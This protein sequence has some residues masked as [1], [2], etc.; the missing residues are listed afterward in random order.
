MSNLQNILESSNC[1][2][3]QEA[4]KI[5]ERIGNKIPAKGYV[6]FETGYGPS[7]LPH[8]GTFGEV[9]RTSIIRHAFTKIS[10]I[11]TRLFAFSDDMDGL[12]KVPDNIPNKDMVRTYLGKPLTSIPDPFGTHESFGHH[13]NNRLRQFLDQFGFEYEF[14]SATDYYKAGK[15]DA[16]LLKTLQHF[17]AIMNVMLPTLGEERQQTYSPI[18]PIC[19]E[20]GEVLQVPILEKNVAKG[21]I[22]FKN[23]K[24]V[25]IEQQ[26]TGGQCKLQWKADWA[27]R[28]C[29][30]DV[31]YE[32]YGKD[33]IPT[34]ELSTKIARILGYQEPVL[35]NYELFLDEKG[36]KISKSKGNGLSMDEWL[37]Y[38][39]EESLSLYMY[40]SPKKAK[41]LFF[42]V[43]P[44]NMDEYLIYL[45]K[46]YTQDLV[47]QV[48]NPVW[49]IHQGNPPKLEP[50]NISF[51]LLLNLASV[52]NPENS[53]VLW[54][55]ISKYAPDVNLQNSP[56]LTKM[57]DFA[58]K[59]YNDFIKP[60]KKYPLLQEI[61]KQTINNLITKLSKLTATA[62][63]D[64]I[65]NCLYDLAREENIESK[66]LFKTLYNMLLG[67][68]Q[69]PRWGTF[70]ALFGINNTIDLAKKA[71][72]RS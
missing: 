70:I 40:Q 28:W 50:H 61:D 3:A 13:M 10:G 16:L 48:E 5:L 49:H 67:Q 22:T 18:L 23:S 71:L 43:I 46:Y 32:M 14:Q 30:L 60:N 11:P 63:N 59:Y 39:P 54:G 51:S 15:F 47:Q 69:G 7:G 64:E 65:Q 29:A 37:T 8:I 26:V 17:D 4:K 44:K 68:D 34:A 66:D 25:I 52:C 12:R 20:S 2:P 31:D 6:L 35:F 62:T 33:L 41:R 27:M 24:G 36:Q 56:M 58:V 45:N 9:A 42:D 1:W 72:E 19:P 53:T 21:T 55:F 57:V 38:A